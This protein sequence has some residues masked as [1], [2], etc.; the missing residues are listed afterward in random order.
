M[1]AGVGAMVAAIALAT[2]T[3]DVSQVVASAALVVVGVA[4]Y[5]RS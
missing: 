3:L 4:L 5:L 1:S 2:G